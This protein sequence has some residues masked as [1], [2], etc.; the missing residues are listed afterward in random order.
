MPQLR[1]SV[2]ASGL[3]QVMPATARWVAKKIGLDWRNPEQIHDPLVNLRLGTSYLKLVLDDLGGS[4]AM[5]AAA[6]NAGPGRPRRWRE[7][8]LLEGP[9]APHAEEHVLELADAL[10]RSDGRHCASSKIASNPPT[11]TSSPSKATISASLPWNGDS[12][13]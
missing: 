4:Q 2:G 11:L 8:P 5:A 10:E 6:Y 9:D 3:M 12:S 7:G 13:S 1:S